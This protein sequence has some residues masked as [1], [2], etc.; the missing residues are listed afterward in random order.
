MQGLSGEDF[1]SVQ[2]F[3]DAVMEDIKDQKRENRI[4]AVWAA[5]SASAQVLKF[6]EAEIRAYQ[7]DYL[8]YYKEYADEYEMELDEFLRDYFNSTEEA[9]R[10]EALEYAES[11]T[12][13][14]M[15]F[16]Q[17]ARLM[18]TT[19]SDEEFDE[20]VQAYYDKEAAS[21]DDLDAYIAY[22]GEDVLR[23]NLIW[24]KSLRAMAERSVRLEP[25]A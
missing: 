2:E 14:D 15:I 7:E 18:G 19:L 8:K 12:K 3:R 6:P 10:Q 4:Y 24:D 25:E 23:E 11:M 16:T 17:L 20:G 9:F 13:N 5:F 22:Y 21:F 1:H